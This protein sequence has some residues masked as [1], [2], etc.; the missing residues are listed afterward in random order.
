M[1]V[2]HCEPIGQLGQR[3]RI[4]RADRNSSQV[5]SRGIHAMVAICYT[6]KRR[7]LAKLLFLLMTESDSHRHYGRVCHGLGRHIIGLYTG[8]IERIVKRTVSRITF[9][10]D[11]TSL[12]KLVNLI[13]INKSRAILFSTLL[14]STHVMLQAIT[15]SYYTKDQILRQVTEM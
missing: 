10:T 5:R 12:R 2:M 4:W 15:K 13:P 1:G 6:T 11:L 8:N 7:A 14:Q 3:L 9:N